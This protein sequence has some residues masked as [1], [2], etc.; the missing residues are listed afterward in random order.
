[1]N[2]I[3]ANTIFL[4]Y[5]FTCM[6]QLETSV[7]TPYNAVWCSIMPVTMAHSEGIYTVEDITPHKPWTD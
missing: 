4:C 1:M 3:L 6:Q 7:Y 2:K 5:Y